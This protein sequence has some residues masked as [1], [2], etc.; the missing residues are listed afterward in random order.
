[1]SALD[2]DWSPRTIMA[3]SCSMSAGIVMTVGHINELPELV[4]IGFACLALVPVI[5]A[6]PWLT[7]R[8]R[9]RWMRPDPGALYALERFAASVV[10]IDLEDKQ[11]HLMRRLTFRILDSGHPLREHYMTHLLHQVDVQAEALADLRRQA[12]LFEHVAAQ[13]RADYIRDHFQIALLPIHPKYSQAILDGSKTV[14]LRKAPLRLGTTHVAIYETAPTS[15]IVGVARILLQDKLATPR[16]IQRAA[17]AAGITFD[18]AMDYLSGGKQPTG[19]HVNQVVRFATPLT[20]AE[21]GVT[22]VPQ[23]ARYLDGDTALLID[24]YTGRALPGVPF[25]AW[26][27]SDRCTITIEV[28]A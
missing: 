4:H 18:K 15:A 8:T 27:N 25:A 3:A 21:A 28:P 13:H 7:S 17:S 26:A 2:P 24:E 19:I 14:E 6:W 20:L 10:R 12:R 16:E 22:S 23:S 9:E 11:F 1:M 5:L